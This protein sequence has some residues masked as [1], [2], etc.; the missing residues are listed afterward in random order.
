MSFI[1]RRLDNIRE[2]PHEVRRQVAFLASG[3]LTGVVAV[4][5]LGLSLYT[6]AFALKG[7][8]VAQM[9]GEAPAPAD[10]GESAGAP[11]VAAAAEAVTT[12][13]QAPGLD[14]VGAGEADRSSTADP[15]SPKS[16]K[17]IIPF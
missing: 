14:V 2:K 15:S 16:G 1:A 9:T 3:V 11:G 8:S 7:A 10:A 13:T 6:G 4:G 5:W 17:T 12:S